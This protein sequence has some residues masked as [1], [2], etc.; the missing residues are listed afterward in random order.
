LAVVYRISRTEGL[1]HVATDVLVCH[2]LD[3]VR[4]WAFLRGVEATVSNEVPVLNP[5]L[6][7]AVGEASDKRAIACRELGGSYI[8]HAIGERRRNGRSVTYHKRFRLTLLLFD[9]R[10]ISRRLLALHRTISSTRFTIS[11]RYLCLLL[12]QLSMVSGFAGALL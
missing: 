11:L 4:W 12:E 9:E 2:L 1:L 3:E 5:H 7:L 10:F 8:W 6:S